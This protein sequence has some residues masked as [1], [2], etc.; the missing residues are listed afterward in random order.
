M[1]HLLLALCAIVGVGLGAEKYPRAFEDKDVGA[2]TVEAVCTVEPGTVSCWDIAG[3]PAPARA[4]EIQRYLSTSR[5]QV[6]FA[7]DAQNLYLVVSC[8]QMTGSDSRGLMV[9]YQSSNVQQMCSLT[10]PMSDSSSFT[11]RS[12]YW[13]KAP[14]DAKSVELPFEYWSPIIGTF[15]L[16][17]TKGATAEAVGRKITFRSAEP[18]ASNIETYGTDRPLKANWQITLDS[19]GFP[20][21][22][23]VTATLKDAE[24]NEI[25]AV[26][27]KGTPVAEGLQRQEEATLQALFNSGEAVPARKYYRAAWQVQ[28]GL[29]GQQII[30]TNVDPSHV[31]SIS[32][33]CRDRIKATI[34]DIPVPPK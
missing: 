25:A 20:E 14:K 22:S 4:E 12:V 32:A 9:S 24:G 33:T 13:V 30:V 26:D 18:G 6:L 29:K 17:A 31:A 2:I 15:D 27:E 3:K 7:Y 19:E 28:R 5:Q 11:Q 8:R 34:T 21:S 10:S 16:K 23:N 1:K